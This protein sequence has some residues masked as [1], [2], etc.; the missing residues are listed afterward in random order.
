MPRFPVQ[1][2]ATAQLSGVVKVLPLAV[3]SV[4]NSSGQS[5]TLYSARTGSTTIANPLNADANGTYSFWLDAGDSYTVSFTLG[6]I[7]G[8]FDVKDVMD[9]GVETDFATRAAFVAARN[10]AEEAPP[11][12]TK[13]FCGDISFEYDGVTTDITD[14]VGWRPHAGC[15][16]NHFL[17]NTSQ[18]TTDMSA[19]MQAAVNYA[20]GGEVELLD[21]VYLFNSVTISQ[22]GTTIRGQGRRNTRVS[23]NS[24][25]ANTF[26]ISGADPFN[27]D[28][29]LG[30]VI[31]G[32]EMLNN[33]ANPSAGAHVMLDRAGQCEIRDCSLFNHYRG[34]TA[35]GVE[36]S[37]K[38]IGCEIT[39]GGNVF[40]MQSGSAGIAVLRREVASS[41]GSPYLDSVDGNYYVEPNS[42]YVSDCNIRSNEGGGASGM[43]FCLFLGAFDG[44]YLDNSHL[45]FAKE[46]VIGLCPQQSN[47]SFTN[48]MANGLFIDPKP[49]VTS[50]GVRL[51]NRHS[52]AT[53]VADN[54]N[55]NGCTLGGADLDA[56]E[57]LQPAMKLA[58]KRVVVKRPDYAA[59]LDEQKPSMAIETKKNRFDV[60]VKASMT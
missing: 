18:G 17:D 33:S 51:Y 38:L 3:V 22:T 48:L 2:T 5:A 57:S 23:N 56:D 44:L 36:E 10:S 26:A 15:T 52:I 58:A 19:A 59:W 29:V 13:A 9:D 12:G 25:T 24:T 42:V 45:G 31:E 30:V 47:L 32:I 14:L 49:T 6:A 16:P 50:Y 53:S 41:V 34:V 8:S 43:E 39:Q 28:Q 37:C 21:E 40:V 7:T 20:N 55:F 27:G 11:V 46:A 35:L 54:M 60:Y 4:L 1:S